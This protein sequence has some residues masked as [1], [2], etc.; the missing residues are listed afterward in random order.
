MTRRILL[1]I[2]ASVLLVIVAFLVPL[3]VFIGDFAVDR[4]QR[5]AVL[6]LQPL[7]SSLSSA[8]TDESPALVDGFIAQ[9]GFETTVYYPDGTVVGVDVPRDRAVDLALE[10]GAFFTPRG[11]GRDLLAPLFGVP[12]TAG[13]VAVVRMHVPETQLTERVVAS[14]LVL[15]L[16]GVVLLALALLVGLLLARSFLRPIRQLTDMAEA[17][18]SGDLTAREAPPS[19]PEIRNVGIQLNRLATR[20]TE[21][22]RGEREQ[23]ADLAHRLR[24]PV[25]ALKLDADQVSVETERDRLTDDVTRL[26]RMVDEVIREARRPVREGARAACDAAAVVRDRATFWG[27]LAEDQGRP[28]VVDVPPAPVLVRLDAADLGDAL[29]ALLGNVFAHTPEGTGYRVRVVADAGGGAEV[30]VADEGPGLPGEAVLAR[31]A[32]GAGS[33]GLGLDIA[34][35]TAESSGGSLRLGAA[36]GGGT[37]VTLELGPPV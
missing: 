2:T 36:A 30:T 12:G 22:L 25:T 6:K 1:A 24:T 21:L 5:E 18:A 27:V 33:T 10:G 28:V 19:P 20:V 3:W 16:L 37:S 14:R 35:R 15:L 4:G 13:Q 9:T 26:E 8:T 23:V 31:G 34:R 17:M 11:N 7:I 32:S 29:D